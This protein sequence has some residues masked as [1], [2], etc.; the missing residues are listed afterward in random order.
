MAL[1]PV[2][3]LL[4]RSNL[5]WHAGRLL[6]S[7]VSFVRLRLAAPAAESN[8]ALGLVVAGGECQDKNV[9]I[10]TLGRIE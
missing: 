4:P 9:S 6:A 8:G 1:A 5:P 2:Q 7:D 3:I 10:L